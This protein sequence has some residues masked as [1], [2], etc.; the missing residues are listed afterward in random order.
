M[1]T[2]VILGIVSYGD[3]LIR[4]RL[5]GQQLLSP[6]MQSTEMDIPIAQDLHNW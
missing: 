3:K 4:S 2:C 1:F 5:Q 6:W